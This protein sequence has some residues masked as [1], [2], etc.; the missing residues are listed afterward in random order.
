MKMSDDLFQPPSFVQHF[1]K[2]PPEILYHHTG[3]VGLLGIIETKE[4]WATKIQ[5]MN[6]ATEFGLA[7]ALARK[8][9]ERV[10]SS[11]ASLAEKSACVK[12]KESLSGLEDINIFA[13]CFCENGDLLSQW[14][15]IAAAVTAI[16]LDSIPAR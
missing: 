10:L 13:V 4:L 14:R 9:L 11:S 1:E 16:Q 8:E 15:G 5:Y 12:L 6:D 7:L 3:Q 2:M